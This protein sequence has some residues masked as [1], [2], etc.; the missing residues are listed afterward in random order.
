VT[1]G[2]GAPPRPCR[3]GRPLPADAPRQRRLCDTCLPP[4]QAEFYRTRSRRV[5]PNGGRRGNKTLPQKNAQQR[6]F[7]E[8]AAY[9]EEVPPPPATRGDCQG[10]PRPCPMASCRY[11][12]AIEV[13]GRKGSLL[14]NHPHR[15]L[16]E[17]PATCALDVADEGTTTLERVAELLNL[18][19]ERVRQI[20]VIALAKVKGKAPWLV[21]HVDE[22]PGGRRRLPLLVV[23]DEADDLEEADEEGNL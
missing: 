15:E 22:G 21:E 7:A 3:C 10:G 6:V 20:E 8:G 9:P 1:G 5:N 4:K 19:R 11:H 12:L 14:L 23:D 17:L 16:D 18:T 2:D 13:V